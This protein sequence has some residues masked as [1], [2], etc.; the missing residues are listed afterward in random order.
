MS[1]VSRTERVGVVEELQA[2]RLI[3]AGGSSG[4]LIDGTMAGG[5]V[6]GRESFEAAGPSEHQASSSGKA[7]ANRS[8]SLARQIG[9]DP[10]Q[11][12]A[13]HGQQRTPQP[14]QPLTD[15]GGIGLIGCD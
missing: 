9:L 5:H 15:R 4:Q 11:P 1:A 13:D 3:A 12:L 10:I 14:R 6:G 8:Q 2:Q 7:V